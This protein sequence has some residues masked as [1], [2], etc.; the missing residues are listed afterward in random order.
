M[1]LSES[2]VELLR[3]EVIEGEREGEG[4]GRGGCDEVSRWA[5]ECEKGEGEGDILSSLSTNKQRRVKQTAPLPV[6]LL[7]FTPT[8]PILASHLF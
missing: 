3:R 5:S 7:D 6:F 2:V 1:G 4:R 8:N